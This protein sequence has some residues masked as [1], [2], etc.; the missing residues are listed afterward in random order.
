MVIDG[1]VSDKTYQVIADAES[2]IPGLYKVIRFE[3]NQGLGVALQKGLEAC[4]NEIVMRMDSDD[5]AVPDRF[6]KQL[7]FMEELNFMVKKELR[8]T[9][10]SIIYLGLLGYMVS[11]VIISLKL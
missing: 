8:K 3:K 9:V 11:A 6:E 2:S 1:P 4:T 7:Q 10:T 5:I